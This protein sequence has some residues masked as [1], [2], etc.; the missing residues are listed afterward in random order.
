MP[1]LSRRRGGPAAPARSAS[2]LP[3]A[4][5][6]APEPQQEKKRGGILGWFQDAGDW[7]GDQYDDVTETLGKAIDKTQEVASDIW[8]VVQTTNVSWDAGKIG[9]ET[10]LD[11]ILDLM[12]ESVREKIQLGDGAE[13][14]IKLQFDTESNTLSASSKDLEIEGMDIGGLKSGAASFQDV[15]IDIRNPGDA[16]AMLDKPREAL[17]GEDGVSIDVS[18][19]SGRAQDVSWTG[20]DGTT[21]LS[22]IAVQDFRGSASNSDGLPFGDDG[23]PRGGGPRG[24]ARARECRRSTALGRAEEVDAEVPRR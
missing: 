17:G 19:G 12:P 20:E 7:I 18:V 6:L 11:E 23:D 4:Q 16:L 9:V 8:D 22:S 21:T 5:T 15:Q 3:E 14:R 10:D 1:S 24:S 2:Q 13:N